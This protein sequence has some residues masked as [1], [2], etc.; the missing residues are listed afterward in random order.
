MRKDLFFFETDVS[1]IMCRLQLATHLYKEHLLDDDHFLDWIVNSL[2]TCPFERLF[3]WLL[4]VSV[5]HYWTDITCCRRR[6]KRL[7]EA[8]LNQLDKVRTSNIYYRALLTP[9]KIYRL[10]D[11]TP[12]LA[13]LQYLESTVVKLLATRPACLLLPSTWTRHSILLQTLVERRNLPQITQAVKKLDQRNSRLLQTSKSGASK[14]QTPVGRVYHILDSV[15]YHS[16]V[17][18]EDLS[19]E[20][21][22]VISNATQLIAV[23]LQ[24]ACTCYRGGAHRIYLATRLLRR[25]SHVGADVYDG[26]ITFLRDISW[27]ESSEPNIIFKIVA[28][29][30]R[31]KTFAAGRYLQWLIATGSL[32]HDK[33]LSSVSVL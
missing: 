21:M 5:P 10:E 32:G 8:L 28:E 3:I 17:R 24:W 26:V 9:V 7:A 15:N 6:G 30:V 31:S 18:I 19:F 13:V 12:Y 22:D 11:Q 25:W 33:D 23:L 29:L 2:D 16:T 1:L 4:V 14:S 27:V 20:C